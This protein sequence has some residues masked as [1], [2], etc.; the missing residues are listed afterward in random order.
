MHADAY[1]EHF[2]RFKTVRPKGRLRL[3]LVDNNFLLLCTVYTR[4][5]KNVCSHG[6][7]SVDGADGRPAYQQRTRETGVQ[8]VAMR[9]LVS[10]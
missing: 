3:R 10:T 6:T 5:Q 4:S 7:A 9:R 2:L 1:V 8:P